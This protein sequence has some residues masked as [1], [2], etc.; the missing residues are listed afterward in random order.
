MLCLPSFEP[1][2]DSPLSETPVSNGICYDT[3]QNRMWQELGDYTRYS[4]NLVFAFYA[5]WFN[6]FTNK[7]AGKNVSM[8]VII[9]ACLNSAP[10]LRY[11][12]E[13]LFVAG[14]IPGPREPSMTITNNI[15]EPL[16]AHR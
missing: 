4:G 9:L 2:V 11:K 6:P 13:F 1:L 10:D 8:G 3:G 7:I 5:D 16:V 12:S 15:L 14:I